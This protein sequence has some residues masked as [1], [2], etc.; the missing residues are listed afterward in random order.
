MKIDDEHL[1]RGTARGVLFCMQLTII[2]TTLKS[3]DR[4]VDINKKYQRIDRRTN[5]LCYNRPHSRQ[6][7]SL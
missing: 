3:T 1:F 7:C 4:P 2:A 5:H 6:R